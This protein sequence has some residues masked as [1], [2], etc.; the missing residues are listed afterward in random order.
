MTKSQARAPSWTMS[1]RAFSCR[2]LAP[3]SSGLSIH[4]ADMA[5]RTTALHPAHAILRAFPFSL[6]LAALVSDW[7][8]WGTFQIQWANFSSWLIVGGLLGG[9]LALLWR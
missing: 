6:F 2:G 1:R 8:Y 3:T 7:A 9:G 4:G 5:G